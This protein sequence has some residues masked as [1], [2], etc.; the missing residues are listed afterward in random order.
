MVIKENKLIEE[1]ISARTM[2]S[3]NDCADDAMN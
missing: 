1:E 2:K 3:I